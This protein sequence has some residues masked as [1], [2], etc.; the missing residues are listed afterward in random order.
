[1]F[2]LFVI[3]GSHHSFTGKQL[4]F[5]SRRQGEFQQDSTR[6]RSKHRQTERAWPRC[7]GTG[8]NIT[9]TEAIIVTFQVRTPKCFRY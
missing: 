7:V 2:L 4:S 6:R 9:A 8:E 1:M 3:Q 5:S